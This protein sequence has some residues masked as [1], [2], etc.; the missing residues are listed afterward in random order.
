MYVCMY[1]WSKA[2]YAHHLLDDGAAM[3]YISKNNYPQVGKSHPNQW[4]TRAHY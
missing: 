4:I 2:S 1:V 3:D